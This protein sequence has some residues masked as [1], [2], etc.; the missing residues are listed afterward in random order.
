[1]LAA[2]SGG[3]ASLHGSKSSTRPLVL[4]AKNRGVSDWNPCGL[5]RLNF[6]RVSERAT[7]VGLGIPSVQSYAPTR[8]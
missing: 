1:M 7:I 2:R 5:T 6:R 3:K 8:V 4:I